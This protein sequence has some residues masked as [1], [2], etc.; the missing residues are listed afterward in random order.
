MTLQLKWRGVRSS[1]PMCPAEAAIPGGDTACVETRCGRSPLIQDL[2]S[3]VVGSGVV[4][5]G[6]PAPIGPS[7]TADTLISD[8]PY[9]PE[10]FGPRS[11]FTHSKSSL[12]H[13][14][15][16]AFGGMP[17]P[18]SVATG[19][20]HS[21]RTLPPVAEAVRAIFFDTA[22]TAGLAQTDAYHRNPKE[23]HV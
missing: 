16:R 10:D 7:R 13:R 18:I 3:S 9:T 8:A 15:P 23:I 22:C 17:F 5:P 20:R 12:F 11:S 19:P 6:R 2:G 21:H 1:A 4:S 14:H